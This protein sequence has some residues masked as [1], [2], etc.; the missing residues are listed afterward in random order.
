[1]TTTKLLKRLAIAA[2]FLSVTAH[3]A[4]SNIVFAQEDGTQVANFK[5]NGSACQLK[6][7]VIRCT[8]NN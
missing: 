1:M 5:L 8:P 3:A 2:L 7:D 6:K 4:D